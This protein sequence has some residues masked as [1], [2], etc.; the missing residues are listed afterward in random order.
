MSTINTRI[1]SKRD[2]TA[3]WNNAKGF[4]PKE[5]EL[6]IY[7]DYQTELDSEGNTINIPGIKVGDGSAYVQDLPFV[8]QDLRA[9]VGDHIADTLIHVTAQEKEFWNN[10]LN[11]N[12][13]QEVEGETLILNRD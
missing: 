2:T 7:M 1:Q 8:D 9:L 10:K 3:N 11:V 13:Y 4:V 12:D 6:I 5:G